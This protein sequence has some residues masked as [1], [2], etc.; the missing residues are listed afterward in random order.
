MRGKKLNANDRLFDGVVI[1]NPKRHSDRSS[2]QDARIFPYYAGYSTAFTEQLLLSL[3]LEEDSVVFD[4]W[5]GSGTTTQ[6]AHRAGLQCIGTDLN[7]VMVVVAKA[8]LLSSLEV[9]SLLPLAQT[10]IDHAANRPPELT[11]ID[12]DPLH[13]WLI[14]QSTSVIRELEQE[15]HRSLVSHSSYRP[16]TSN[17][18]LAAL[19]FE[20]GKLGPLGN[21]RN[22]VDVRGG[23]SM[24]P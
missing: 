9:E 2:A 18:S 6:T 23:S 22:F 24:F 17:E 14:P 7:P 5:N 15:I 13:T 3:G 20:R 21:M 11:N 1:S 10:I 12:S 16:L 8:G 4:P 19:T